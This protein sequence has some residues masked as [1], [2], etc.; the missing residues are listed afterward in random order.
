MSRASLMTLVLAGLI[1]WISVQA[2]E[3]ESEV[4]QIR[5]RGAAEVE[6]AILPF[7][8]PEGATVVMNDR[9]IVR[10]TPRNMAEIRELIG[11]LDRG[12]RQ[13]RIFV[14]HA[15]EGSGSKS[16]AGVSGRVGTRSARVSGELSE[17]NSTGTTEGTQQ[18]MALEGE[19]ATIQTD[20]GSMTVLPRIMGDMVRLEVLQ[21]HEGA[22][23]THQ[24]VSSVVAAKIG[25]WFSLGG[26]EENS[27]Q[28]NS[29]ILRR[30]GA[31]SARSSEVRVRVELVR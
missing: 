13:L 31:K 12:A 3:T 16:R 5:H 18:L 24:K 17:Q 6:K 22:A 15:S 4:F 29:A 9:L 23:A 10:A 21:S 30:E 2:Y 20:R 28:T 8:G 14:S 19:P 1:S 7:L 27:T 26:T 11:Q 25:E